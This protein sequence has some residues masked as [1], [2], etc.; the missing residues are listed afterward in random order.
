MV[1][2]E[3]LQASLIDIITDDIFSY[4]MDVPPMEFKVHKKSWE[5]S[6][7]RM[8]SRQISIEKQGLR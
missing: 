7:N 8:A 2:S 5:S 4:S 6:G 1:G 3:K